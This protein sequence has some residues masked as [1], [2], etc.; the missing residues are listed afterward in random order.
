MVISR[1]VRMPEAFELIFDRHFGAVH[2]YL[3]RRGGIERADDLASQ[4]F[5][6][7]FERRESFW[8]DATDARPWLF[9]IATR[10]LANEWRTE[11]RRLET[12]ARLSAD[13]REAVA[14]KDLVLDSDSDV[15]AALARLDPA[16][17]DVLL[18][19]VWGDLSYEQIAEALAIPIGTVRSR[20][21]RARNGLQVEFDAA[22]TVSPLT[23]A[24]REVSS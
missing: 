23:E 20:L 21:A 12:F 24:E 17:R 9:G 13:A 11:Q 6:I 19:Y 22:G 10:L 4:T 18:L 16:Q 2:R 8:R 14:S 3:A 15:A 5:V 7:A 1:S